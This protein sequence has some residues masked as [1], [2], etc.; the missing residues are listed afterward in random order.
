MLRTFGDGKGQ[1]HHAEDHGQCG[2]QNRAQSHTGGQQQGFTA[3]QA[4]QELARGCI[5]LWLTCADG[6]VHQQDGILGHQPHEHDDADD[7]EHGQGRAKHH[8]C[9]HHADQ[10]QRQRSHE[11]QRLQEALEL[12]GQNH[13]DE[14]DGQH[15]RRNGIT[16]GLGHVL[17]SAAELVAVARRHGNASQGLTDIAADLARAAQIH[18]GVDGDLAVEVAAVDLAGAGA[19]EHAGDLVE[20]HDAQAA[21]AGRQRKGQSLQVLWCGARLG[22]EAHIDVIGLVIAGAPVAHRLASHPDAQGVGH[23]AHGKPQICCGITVNLNVHQRLVGLETGVQINQARNVINALLNDLTQARQ[24]VKV[25]P[26]ERELHLLLSTH[27]FAQA[28]MGDLDAGNGLQLGTQ[29]GRNFIHIALALMSVH[30][31][32]IDIGVVLAA[33]VAGIDGGQRVAHL[34]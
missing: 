12:A 13:V 22:R 17:G 3:R 14:D 16:K 2:H 1:R 20:A 15:Q 6:E 21:V 9:Q 28:H 27:G 30:Q 26:H 4:G 7:G 5:E 34:G 29:I 31:A 33:G 19:F 11:R 18:V 8:Q 32:H 24:L 25:R 10:R 23:A